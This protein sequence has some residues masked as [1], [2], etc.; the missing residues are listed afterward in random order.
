MLIY[1]NNSQD[2]EYLEKELNSI[3]GVVD[4]GIFSHK[5]ITGV[6]AGDEAGVKIFP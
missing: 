3:P 4:N 2:L 6:I 1:I 5:Y